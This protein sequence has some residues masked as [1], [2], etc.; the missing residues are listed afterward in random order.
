MQFFAKI[1]PKIVQ[2][3][4]NTGQVGTY[5]TQPHWAGQLC[6]T[7]GCGW[8][9]LLISAGASGVGLLCG[10]AS[11][12]LWRL[13][14]WRQLTQSHSEGWQWRCCWSGC[15]G[16]SE[17]ENITARPATTSFFYLPWFMGIVSIKFHWPEYWHRPTM[18]SMTLYYCSFRFFWLPLYLT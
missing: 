11:V 9:L 2:G 17:A 6:W 16:R 7:A 12:S 14:P 8:P 5:W 10:R 18:Y 1:A 13:T 15:Y 3:K 4:K